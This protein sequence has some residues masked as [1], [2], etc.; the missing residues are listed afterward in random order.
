MSRVARLRMVPQNT[1][2]NFRQQEQLCAS[3]RDAKEVRHMLE[4]CEDEMQQQTKIIHHL[5]AQNEIDRRKIA[6]MEERYKEG[7]S[8]SE[9]KMNQIIEEAESLVG[10]GESLK[11]E[12]ELA[13]LRRLK[14][15]DQEMHQF[16]QQWKLLSPDGTKPE[17][18]PPIASVEQSTEEINTV[19]RNNLEIK[20]RN[21]ERELL[22]Q[23]ASLTT[24]KEKIAL[25]DKEAFDVLGTL[26]DQ[27]SDPR[28]LN[29]KFDELSA[30]MVEKEKKLMERKKKMLQDRVIRDRLENEAV[31]NQVDQQHLSEIMTQQNKTNSGTKGDINELQEKLQE[32]TRQHQ[33]KYTWWR[34]LHEEE[35]S[36]VA[37]RTAIDEV[38]KDKRQSGSFRLQD[39]AALLD[40]QNKVEVKRSDFQRRAH[41]AEMAVDLSKN[42]E[43][44][45]HE[46]L[47]VALGMQRDL[48]DQHS[49][50]QNHLLKLHNTQTKIE[51]E[52]SDVGSPSSRSQYRK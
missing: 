35:Q 27:D 50:A 21:K 38:L 40:L 26:L 3:M 45:I 41:Q 28:N 29:Q 23:N 4:K 47:V 48:L 15:H 31:A 33:A 25:V 52:L 7:I 14:K 44:D 8:A 6:E 16:V 11:I 36:L 20:I 30:I 17:Q 42:E 13:R 12:D 43:R 49:E 19:P 9:Q 46:E 32:A 22:K 18:R 34:Q 2:F 51:K 37:S 10:V 24:K 1:D 39:E 5:T